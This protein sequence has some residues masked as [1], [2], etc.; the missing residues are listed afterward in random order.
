MPHSC[1]PALTFKTGHIYKCLITNYR[2][3]NL[4]MYSSHLLSDIL[5][6]SGSNHTLNLHPNFIAWDIANFSFQGKNQL[7]PVPDMESWWCFS[8]E[9]FREFMQSLPRASTKLLDHFIIK[10]T[11][12]YF[13]LNL[14]LIASSCWSWRRSQSFRYF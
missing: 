8:T 2:S 12:V 1:K 10:P 11:L 4:C 6:I 7:A 3:F 5:S 13:L 9:L 14:L